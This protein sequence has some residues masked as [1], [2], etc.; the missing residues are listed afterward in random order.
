MSKEWRI[1]CSGFYNRNW[2]GVFYPEDFPQSKFFNYYS[3]KFNSLELNVTFYRFPKTE[4]LKK[5]HDKSPGGFDFAV[6]AP[7]LITHMKKLNDCDRLLDDF[8]SACED[9]LKEKLGC[10]LFQFPPSYKYTEE[11]LEQVIKSLRSEF[12]NVIEF[13][14]AG[15]WNK[16]V[17][18]T[19]AENKIIFCTVNHPKL[20]EDIVI[21]SDTAY[22]RLHGNPD[23]FYSK[24][25]YEELQKLYAAVNKKRKVKTIYIFFNNTASTAGVLNALEMKTLTA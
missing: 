13:R 4:T 14:D 25:S 16:K 7:K 20:P 19:L 21:N 1:G 9:G 24:Y 5:W 12:K 15:W 8:Y 6:K 10:T 11:R 18:D 23:I 3:E 17:Y 22:I 2:K